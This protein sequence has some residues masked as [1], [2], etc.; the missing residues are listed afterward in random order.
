MCSSSHPG[1]LEQSRITLALSDVPLRAAVDYIARA[2]NLKTKI[3]PYA[4]V[5]VPQSEPTDVLITKEYKVPPNF[6]SALPSSVT[7]PTAAAGGATTTVAPG[8][9]SVLAPLSGAKDFL[10]SEGVSFPPGASANYISSTS[11]LIVKNTQANLD[12]IDNLVETSLS[13]P[14]NQVKIE[15]KFLEIT[16]NNLTELG[17][18]WL[19]GQFALPGGTGVYGGGGTTVGGSNLDGTI[20][21]TSGSIQNG[22][23]AYPFVN[24]SSSIPVGASSQTSGPLTAGNRSGTAAIQ[25]NALDAL[26]FGSPAGPAPGIL[27]LAGVFTNPQFQVVIQALNQKKGVDLVSAP[28][29]TTESGKRATI[30]IVREFRYPSEYSNPQ[31]TQTPGGILTPV[32]PTTPTAFDMRPTGVTL[33]VEPTVGPDGYTI[34]MVLAPRIVDFLGFINY[35]SPI[36][37]TVTT[38]GLG[39]ANVS[40]NILITSNVI[41]RPVFQTREVTTQVSVADGSTVV[42]GGLISENIQKTEDKVPILGDIPI[43]GRL[44]R[45][46]ADQHIKT[47]LIIFVTANLLDPAGQMVATNTAEDE[48]APPGAGAPPLPTGAPAPG[49]Q[50]PP[51]TQPVVQ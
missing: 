14:P 30:N 23:T 42:L 10:V 41:N 19:L 20:T 51:A 46:S 39:L 45:S 36:F 40:A 22:S 34:D 38:F 24:P 4:V 3:E 32:T 18:N 31:I 37:A 7:S 35:G 27:A 16:Q 44:F 43:A 9:T 8:S 25:A 47:N 26:L 33:E 1:L 29:V 13:T 11:K 2:A 50:S 15:A 17:F 6:I 21:S 48:D 49:T 12:L 28:A 5:V